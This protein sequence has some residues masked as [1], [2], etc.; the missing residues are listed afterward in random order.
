MGQPTSL[1]RGPDKS[2][3]VQEERQTLPRWTDPANHLP[4][5]QNTHAG[6]GWLCSCEFLTGFPNP[7]FNQALSYS[8]WRGK[9]LHGMHF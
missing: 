5:R 9:I 8:C 3:T 7:R 2:G 4:G 6:I 1:G